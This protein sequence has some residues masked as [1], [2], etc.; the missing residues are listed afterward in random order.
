M[1]AVIAAEAADAPV[2]V[3]VGKKKLII[4]VAAA[5]VVLLVIGGGVGFW[6]KHKAAKAAFS[7][8]KP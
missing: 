7:L 6:L 1:S 4:L 3:K 5:L 8:R 2:P